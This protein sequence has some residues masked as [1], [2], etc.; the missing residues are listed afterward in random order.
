M[1]RPTSM[2]AFLTSLLLCLS[3]L[4][5]SAAEKTAVKSNLDL[6]SDLSGQVAHDLISDFQNQLVR[7]PALRLV[8]LG[9]GDTYVFLANEFTAALTAQKIRSFPPRSASPA[10]STAGKLGDSNRQSM[11]L[12]FQALEFSLAYSK[13]YR[14]HLFGGKKIKRRAEVKIFA[15][16]LDPTDDSVVWV[17]EASQS[18]KDQFSYNARPEVE[19]GLFDFTKPNVTPPNW[20]KIIE[21]VVVSGI[22]VGLVYLF[23]SN[24]SSD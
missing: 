21:P 14:S 13:I 8:P 9:T 10:D 2:S 19:E 22:I 16:L 11:K 1:V 6:M 4:A 12:E 7:V 15:R 20:G 3:V 17:G 18:Q 24:Q 23:Y 5:A